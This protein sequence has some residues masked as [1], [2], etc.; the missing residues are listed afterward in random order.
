MSAASPERTAY[1]AVGG[2]VRVHLGLGAREGI[3][4]FA[5]LLF[6]LWIYIVLS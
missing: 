1:P 3:L 5:E 2:G 6:L 4:R